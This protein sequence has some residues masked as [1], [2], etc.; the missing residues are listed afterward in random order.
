[1]LKL[2]KLNKENYGLLCGMMDEWTKSGER[3]IP[4][5]I[6]I[7]DYKDYETYKN[8]IELKEPTESFVPCSTFFAHDTQRNIFVGAVNIRHY[9]NEDLLLHGGHIGYGVRPSERRKGYATKMLKLALEECK[10]LEIDK[11]LVVCYK[12]NIGS[13]KTIINN[14]GVLENEVLLDTGETDCRY[15]I[16]L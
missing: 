3:I 5:S 15:W 13:A 9:L 4:Y 14:G 7:T 12:S 8:S 11:A 6:R 1:M 2:A 10:K 16:S